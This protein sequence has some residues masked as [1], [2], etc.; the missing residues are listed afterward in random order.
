MKREEFLKILEERLQVLNEQEREDIV[1]EYRQHI[2]MRME[3]GLTEEDAIR[4]FG[5]LNELVG[6]ILDAYSVNPDYGKKQGFD[7]KAGAKAAG[8]AVFAGTKKAGAL[9]KRTAGVVKRWILALFKGACGLMSGIWRGMKGAAAAVRSRLRR[10]EK[11]EAL[12]AAG[13]SDGCGEVSVPAVPEM[14]SAEGPI[15]GNG[16]GN[17]SILPETAGIRPGRR[18]GKEESSR[19]P[20]LWLS[21][22]KLWRALWRL[23]A[24]C[25]RIL[26]TVFVLLPMTAVDF[27]GVVCFGCLLV[28][29]LMGYPAVGLTVG[30]FGGVVSCTALIFL[31]SD[32]L[33]AGKRQKKTAERPA[34]DRLTEDGEEETAHEA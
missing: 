30:A 18:E 21:F 23:A 25:V 27:L 1:S 2:E 26:G 11:R 6:E 8:E 32:V 10:K 24:A 12:T 15:A 4:D 19:R 29:C 9:G 3:S 7:P 34:E 33:F 16:S 14:H 28:L 17:L 31:V 22:G 20:G 13:I 5:D